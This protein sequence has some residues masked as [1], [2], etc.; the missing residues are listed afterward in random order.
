M[1]INQLVLKTFFLTAAQDKQS[2]VNQILQIK[3]V[4]YR[5]NIQNKHHKRHPYIQHLNHALT[6]ALMRTITTK[7]NLTTKISLCC[8]PPL[9]TISMTTHRHYSPQRSERT[10]E[11]IRTRLLILCLFSF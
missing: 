10:R 8:K 5:W 6:S 11:A 2:S 1:I 4:V 9:K 3:T 7:I